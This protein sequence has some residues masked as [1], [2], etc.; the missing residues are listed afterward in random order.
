MR[1]R[2]LAVV[3]L[4][5]AAE[6]PTTFHLAC[7]DHGLHWR[8]ELVVQALVR[9]FFMVMVDK[10]SYGRPEMRFAEKYHAVQAFVLGRLDKPF[11]KRVQIGTP[12]RQDQGDTPLSRSRRRKAPV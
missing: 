12:R 6:S 8:D 5:Q 10:F 4:E 3:E 11:C 2:S 7:S 1:L 9:S